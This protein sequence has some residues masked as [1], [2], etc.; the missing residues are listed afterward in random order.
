MP[1]DRKPSIVVFDVGRVLIQYEPR[2]LYRQLFAEDEALMEWFLA[3]VVSHDWVAAQDRG[4][5]FAEGIALL[6]ERHPDHA[7]AIAAFRARWHEMVPGAIEGTV[8]ILD[9]LRRHHV[10]NYAITNFAADLWPEAVARFP[11]LA[12]FDGLVVSG[13]ARLLKP[14]PEIFHLLLDT[15]GLRAA[16]CVFID[17]LPGNIAAAKAVGME[18]IVFESAETLAADLKAMGFPVE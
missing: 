12:G 6:T 16:D 11:F 2:L 1:R 17:D 15:Y 14:E 4:R 3:E 18:G 13:Q 9:A 7:D 5:P 10:P 8:A